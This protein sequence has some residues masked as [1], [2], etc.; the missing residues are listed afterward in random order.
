MRLGQIQKPVPFIIPD[1]E[2]DLAELCAARNV[3][4][5]QSQ[6][7]RGIQWQGDERARH[8]CEGG[9][10]HA[11]GRRAR[12][13]EKP[14]GC[15]QPEVEDCGSKRQRPRGTCESSGRGKSDTGRQIFERNYGTHSMSTQ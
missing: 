4:V 5:P 12:P 2:A 1:C 14:D 13:A 7:S 6:R 3:F 11:E 9:P 15:R 10:P 8:G